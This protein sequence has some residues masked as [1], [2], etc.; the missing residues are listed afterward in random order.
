MISTENFIAEALS[1][2]VDVRLKL[3]EC[4]LESLNPPHA[5]VDKLWAIEAERRVAELERGEAK[6]VPG[7][8]VFRKIREKLAK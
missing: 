6:T 3:V 4:L 7:D 8:E 2:P 1:L 5:D